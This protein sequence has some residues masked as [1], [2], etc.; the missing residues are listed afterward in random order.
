MAPTYGDRLLRALI[1]LVIFTVLISYNHA[2]FLQY[3]R[4]ELLL[5]RTEVY[6]Q[7]VPR[8]IMD[9][10]DFFKTIPMEYHKR[11]K[12][13]K[14]GGVL[15]RSRMRSTKKVP[16]PTIIMANVQRLWN[17]TDELFSRIRMQRDFRDT[18]I[19]SFCETWLKPSHP[20][21]ALQPPGFTIFRKD[22][23]Q[24]ITNKSQGGGVCFLINDN[25]CTNVKIISDGCTPDLEYITLKCRPF[26]LPRE[27]S[28]VTITTAYIHPRADTEKA[29][30]TLNNVIT[31]YENSDPNTLSIILGDFNQANLRSALPNYHQLVTCKTRGDNI[32]DH[33]Y[34]SIKGAYKSIKRP[35]IGNSDHAT[36][37]LIPAYK[38]QLKQSKP[39]KKTV[40]VWTEEA[41]E[42]LRGCFESTTWDIFRENSN[43]DQYTEAVMDYIKFC[44]NI[45]LPEKTVITYPNNKVWFEQSLKSFLKAKDEAYKNKTNDPAAF[46][47]ARSEWKKAVRRSKQNYK[48]KLESNFNT[49]DS[50]QVWSSISQITNYKGPKKQVVCSDPSLPNQLNEFYARFD[51][52]NSTQPAFAL[53][54]EIQPELVIEESEVR[55]VFTT[56]K[57]K[58][59]PGP[60]G[61]SP[62]LLINCA[63]QL[64]TVFT[65]IYNT[66]LRLCKVP[67]SFK[68]A[69]IIPIPKKSSVS[70][71]NDYRPVALTAIPMKAFERIILKYIKTLLPPDFDQYQFAY[72]SNR[73]TEDAITLCLHRILQHLESPST[74][75][76]VLFIDYSSAFNTIIPSKLHKKLLSDLKFP[77]A[78]CDWILDFLINRQQKVCIQNFH[79]DLKF[80]S[81]GTPQ[82][83]VLS[84]MLYSIFTYDCVALH[85]NTV[86]IKFADDTTI[87]GL[88]SKNDESTYRAQVESTVKWCDENNLTL[89]V[90]K[91]KEIIIDFRKNKNDKRPLLIAD[92]CVEVVDNFKFL[93]AYIANDLKWNINSADI[94]KKA[95][96]RMYF[97]RTLK[98]FNV[99]QPILVSFYRSIIES[100][101]TRSITVWFGSVTQKDIR[102]LNSL[103]RT[104]EKIIGTGLPSLHSIYNDR[105]KK[106]TCAII[107][108]QCHPASHLFEFLPSGKRLRSFYGNKR[109]INSFYP[110]AVRVFNNS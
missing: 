41:T 97:L 99:Q 78:L 27:F 19:F 73:S 66:S 22:R 64:A 12:R 63:S 20:D 110:S 95:R 43:L 104:A 88:I 57:K 28:S 77:A 35:S 6:V 72:R 55:K 15:A 7:D 49:N 48:E 13:G 84:P 106:R 47:K 59:A 51:L 1:I 102:K 23:D 90:A 2:K 83:C 76:R 29:L 4:E 91:T 62:L 65:N 58:K 82:G 5:L 3:S 36:V 105:T 71:L 8:E 109:F 46:K 89:N 60:D 100:I 39:T 101:L 34:C 52:H 33:C 81:T 25:W 107:K 67:S 92:E 68:Q 32:L 108:E 18:C 26:Y 24:S 9:F 98:S 69:T 94:I 21:N 93:G 96:Q 31:N 14:R 74:Y 10:N 44:E 30:D 38:Q 45:C 79:S 56:L 37:L 54:G 75:A 50:K 87:C 42:K 85:D 70:C 80:L 61:V 11:R 40:K 53:S 17:K 16:V 86:I 103:I